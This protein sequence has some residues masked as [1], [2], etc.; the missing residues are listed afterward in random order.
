MLR[1]EYFSSDIEPALEGGYTVVLE[2]TGREVYVEPGETILD[3]VTGIGV[4]V[5]YS[6]QEGVCGSCETRVLQGVPDHRDLILSS[7]ERQEN[8][9]MMICCSGSKSARLVLDL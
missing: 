6:C 9:T 4:D 7:R 8:K 5:P 1:F 2:R 3:V